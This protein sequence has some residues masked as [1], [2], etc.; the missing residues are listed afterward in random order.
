MWLVLD[1]EDD[2]TELPLLERQK[3]TGVSRQ[4]NPT[5][6]P[7]LTVPSQELPPSERRH[8]IRDSLSR[9]FHHNR[10][11]RAFLMRR[12][13]KEEEDESEWNE[14]NELTESLHPENDA[15]LFSNLTIFLQN[16]SKASDILPNGANSTEKNIRLCKLQVKVSSLKD[17]RRRW[18]V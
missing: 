12:P 5:S 13:V 10:L 14:F 16:S 9:R 7:N 18:K 17:L 15:P 2:D 8:L 11:K 6:S 4:A 3:Q 1:N